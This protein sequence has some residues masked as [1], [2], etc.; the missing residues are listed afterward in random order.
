M[1]LSRTLI[2]TYAL[3]YPDHPH[4]VLRAANER[5]LQDTQ[6]D[7]FVTVFYGV[8]DV[9][10][11]RFSYSNAGHNPGYLIYHRGDEQP[12]IRHLPRT[13]IPLGMFTDM[14]WRE[15]IIT[16]G[17]GAVLILYSDGLTEAHAPDSAMFGEDRLLNLVLENEQAT[18]NELQTRIISAVEAFM[19][20]APQFDDITLVTVKRAH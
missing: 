13:G 6:S 8:L 10:M 7:L 1:A 5:I 16:I 17:D 19:S 2:R 4:E 12:T 20:T 3:E 9:G 18:A 11:G 14:K 15:E